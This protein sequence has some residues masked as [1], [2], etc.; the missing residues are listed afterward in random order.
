MADSP[1]RAILDV[2]DLSLDELETTDQSALGAALRRLAEERTSPREETAFHTD[3]TDSH[4]SSP[5]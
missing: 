3:H 4:S 2:S 5:W 1:S